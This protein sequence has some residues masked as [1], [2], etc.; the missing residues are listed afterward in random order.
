MDLFI[1]DAITW[2]SFHRG[3]CIHSRFHLRFLGCKPEQPNLT[4]KTINF[5]ENHV[6]LYPPKMKKVGEDVTH[7]WFFHG[8]NLLVI[9]ADFGSQNLCKLGN[10]LPSKTFKPCTLRWQAPESWKKKSLG[11][12]TPSWQRDP[13]PIG[14]PIL[15]GDRSIFWCKSFRKKLEGFP[16]FHSAWSLGW[17]YIVPGIPIGVF[18]PLK[19]PGIMGN[20]HTCC[21]PWCFFHVS[22]CFQSWLR[23]FFSP[24]NWRW[25]TLVCSL[26]GL[27]SFQLG[28]QNSSSK[29]SMC[30]ISDVWMDWTNMWLQNMDNL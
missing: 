16:G 5:S 26:V 2:C 8:E 7:R 9:S 18:V 11:G 17:F 1:V 6:L 4:K 20:Q 29:V 22:W 12:S 24:L 3:D 10:S 13:W 21:N 19:G 27:C 28:R 25:S 30:K 15:L 23:M 14:S